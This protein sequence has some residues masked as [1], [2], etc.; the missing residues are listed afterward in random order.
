M[1]EYTS[2]RSHHVSVAVD[3]DE[4]IFDASIRN[5]V[6]SLDGKNPVSRG[7]H[8]TKKPLQHLRLGFLGQ[9]TRV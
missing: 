6:V 9:L 8:A 1:Y 2:R 5:N 3:P 4:A 7:K